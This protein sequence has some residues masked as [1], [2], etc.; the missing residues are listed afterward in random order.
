MTFKE[1]RSLAL[2]FPGAEESAHFDRVAF[3]VIKKRIF[4]TIHEPTST[5]NVKL[6]PTDQKALCKFGKNVMYPVDNKWGAQGWTTIELETA[7]DELIKE[8]LESAYREVF[9]KSPSKK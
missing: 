1:F 3:K 2:S 9:K 5:A 8:A 4:A 6:S 7:P